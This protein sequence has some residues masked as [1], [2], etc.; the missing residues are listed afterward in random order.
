MTERAASERQQDALCEL[1]NVGSGHAASMLARLVG[2][3]AV[4]TEVPRLSVAHAGD[5]SGQLD[6]VGARALIV[7][8][9]VEG[10]VSGQL[11]WILHTDD[12]R[13]LAGRLLGRP[14]PA[15]HLSA[16]ERGALAEAA[17]IVASSF[18]SAVGQ[19]VGAPMMPS[20]PD[21]REGVIGK[22]LAAHPSSSDA[23]VV[24]VPFQ[25]KDGPHFGGNLV[26]MVAT[27]DAKSLL[28]QLKVG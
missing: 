21:L 15:S 2:G 4:V 7:G 9:S 28:N 19:M 17:N 5:L 18:C 20:P 10:S 16:E 3:T 22:L 25:S 1:A 12:A 26:L 24:Q 8:F 11:W 27:H 14:A 6:E 13:T 23:V